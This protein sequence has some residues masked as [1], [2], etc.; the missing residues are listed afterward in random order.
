MPRGFRSLGLRRFRTF[1]IE[2]GGF[3]SC[4]CSR[5]SDVNV[6]TL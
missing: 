1:R 6:L 4:V 5:A 2:G 3:G